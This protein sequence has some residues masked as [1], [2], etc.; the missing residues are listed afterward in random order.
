MATHATA[1]RRRRHRRRPRRLHRRDPR[2]AARLQRPPASTS[3]RTSKGGPAPGGT[4]TNVGCI[5]SKALLQS[6]E[7]FEH[8]G[9]HFADH[10][11]DVEGLSD[12]RR[13]RCWRART[14]SSSRTTTASCTC[15]RRTR[16]RFFHGRGSFVEGG[17]GGY[18]IKVA[19]A[20]AETLTGKHVIVAT[21]SNAARACRARRSTRRR[22]LSNDGALRIAARAEDARRRSARA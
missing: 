14:P 1:F 20:K 4:C 7:N 15:S 12:R 13:A 3:G 8:A 17:D 18:E 10:G 2:R 22:I 5:P 16:S 6:S 11:I 9:H 19:G 21:G